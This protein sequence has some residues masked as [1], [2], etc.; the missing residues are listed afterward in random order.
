MTDM[1]AGALQLAE[2]GFAVFPVYGIRDGGCLCNRGA[3]CNDSGKHPIPRRGLSEATKDETVVR[4]WWAQHPEANVAYA[5]GEPSSVIVL[6]VDGAD[7]ADS[8]RGRALPETAVVTTGRPGGYHYCFRYPGGDL[9]SRNGLVPHVDL[10]A[11]GGY[12]VAPPSRH[13]SGRR[14]QWH[15]ELTPRRVGFAPTPTWLLE[16]LRAGNG[17]SGRRSLEEWDRLVREGVGE[18]ARHDEL[19]RL[20][21]LAFQSSLD[22]GVAFEFLHA[23]NQ[24]RCRPPLPE[25]EADRVIRDIA[26]K[27]TARLKKECR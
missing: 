4:E 15:R 11:N 21:G 18:G 27:E 22:P 2:H 3:S 12:V 26:A 6:D 5:T 17:T 14:Y 19:C 20:S 25:Q 16:L 9:R 1:L 23:W 24:V 8:L 7:G 10:K 13:S